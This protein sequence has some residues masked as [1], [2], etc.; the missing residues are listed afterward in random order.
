MQKPI[1]ARLVPSDEEGPATA[2]ITGLVKVVQDAMLFGTADLFP[3]VITD[4]NDENELLLVYAIGSADGQASYGVASLVFN[5]FLSSADTKEYA[6]E[7]TR[8]VS[9]AIDREV[10]EQEQQERAAAEEHGP[11]ALAAL[12]AEEQLVL[13]SQLADAENR[14]L[15][16]TYVTDE[17]DPS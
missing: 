11:E 6:A 4:E 15:S 13:D 1:S 14:A 10:Y 7:V 16:E 9:E 5:R 12:R 2:A 8:L 17:E 3:V